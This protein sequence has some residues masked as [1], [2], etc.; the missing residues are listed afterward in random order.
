LQTVRVTEKDFRIS[1]PEQLRAGEVR[2]VSQNEG[3]DTHELIVVRDDGGPLPLRTDGLT[4]NEEAL[5]PRIVASA[6]GFAS[7]THVEVT[8]RLRP[9]RYTLL[10]NMA[11]HYLAGMHREIVVR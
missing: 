5:Q 6:D 8:A 11:G 10:C 4:V 9:G 3:P 1:A 7:Q 2:F